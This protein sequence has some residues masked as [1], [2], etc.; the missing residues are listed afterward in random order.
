M[1]FKDQLKKDLDIFIN[2]KEFADFHRLDGI[3]MPVVIDEFTMDEF[4]GP[5]KLESAMEGIY[6][7]TKTIY[8]KSA[9][10]SKPKVGYRLQLDEEDYEVIGVSENMGMLKI[11]L[12]SYES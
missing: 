1:N 2:P 11:D 12:S 3:E 6:Q 5:Q 10:Y 4:S 8:V 7:S 9:A